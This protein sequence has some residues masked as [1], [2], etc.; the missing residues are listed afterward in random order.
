MCFYGSF[1]Q[2]LVAFKLKDFYSIGNDNN[3]NDEEDYDDG[4]IY[5]NSW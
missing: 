5:G 1:I 3:G 4:S 2:E